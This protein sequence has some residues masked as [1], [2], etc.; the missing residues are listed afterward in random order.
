M[1]KLSDFKT[2]TKIYGLIMFMVLC[3]LG[4]GLAG[5][6]SVNMLSHEL[7]MMYYARLVPV[8]LL[9]EVRL[10]SKDSESKLLEIML[11]ADGNK[12]KAIIDNIQDN[13]NRINKLQ[14]D[15]KKIDL[16]TYQQ[17]K[18][19]ELEKE[20]TDYRQ[21][22]QDIIKLATSGRQDAAFVLYT[23]SMPIFMQATE[24]RRDLIDYNK[25]TAAATNRQG[26]ADAA[27]VTK[28]IAIVTGCMILLACSCGWL[29]V[30][31]IANPLKLL[32]KTVAAVAGG[33]LGQ[34][35]GFNSRDEIGQ[36]GI[37][38]NS[39]TTDLGR[40]IGQVIDTTGQVAASSQ[41]LTASADQSA[42][43]ASQV[44]SSI[45]TVAEV[46]Q[47]QFR[48]MKQTLGS[49]EDMA[50][51]IRYMAANASEVALAT[52]KAALSAQRGSQAVETAI[53]QMGCIEKTVLESAAVITGL[54]ARSAQI[55][56]IVS[57]ISGI[58]GQTNLLALNAAIE[59]ARAGEQGR[60]FA[61]VADE[62][63]MLAEQSQVAAKK[64]AALLGEIHM[65]TN[66]A[67]VAMRDG[68]KEVKTGTQVVHSSGETF[69]EIVGLIENV[70]VQV[71]DISTEIQAVA[72]NSK[73]IVAAVQAVEET[74]KAILGQTETVSAATEEQSAAMAEIAA[75]SQ[76]LARMAEGLSAATRRF[77]I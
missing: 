71:Q 43:A 74:G 8:Q 66:K 70:S 49:V 44:A 4:V 63:R 46:S 34:Q 21:A 9:G 47:D 22:R 38:F 59:A 57:V 1:Y 55:G 73:Q 10:L 20:L 67:A 50:A 24:L 65:D 17:N 76:A 30:R 25:D 35:V 3:L 54:E 42:V 19:S 53:N 26:L 14:A 72:A 5:L 60:G 16:D 37:A 56:E 40:L 61:V 29:I 45:T 2:A 23:Q 77:R 58:A 39:M 69:Q 41:Q 11:T 64:I 52:D 32:M 27:R 51:R 12:H 31:V 75:A 68:T 28:V 7:T 48:S 36:L 33:D 15:Y 6:F 62:V 13:T 18:L